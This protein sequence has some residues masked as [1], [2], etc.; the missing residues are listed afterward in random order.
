[1]SSSRKEISLAEKV[2]K[3]YFQE[4]YDIDVRGKIKQKNGL[5]YL[6]WAAAWAEVKKIHPDATF[7]VYEEVI[8]DR[9]NTRPWFDDGKTGWVK[10]G[11]TINGIELIEQ[12][13]IMDFRNKSIPAENIT[14]YDANKS[15]QRSLTKACARHGLGLFIFEGEDLPEEV[16]KEEK[17]KAE[18]AKTELEAINEEN[19]ELAKK[20]SS[21][22]E[23]KSQISTLCKKYVSNGNPRRM[24]D[25][26]QSKKLNSELKAM[27][28]K[29]PNK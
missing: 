8:D 6:S 24:T 27:E 22:A 10:T 2:E 16:K 19:F 20:L 5:N 18:A 7:K 21:V 17:A 4:L 9:G 14:S 23:L 25:L 28:A 11:V 3:N 26:A 29:L 15:V 1:M 12:L 13:P